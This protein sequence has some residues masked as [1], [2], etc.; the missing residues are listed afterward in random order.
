MAEDAD[1]DQKTEDPTDKKKRDAVGEG[2]VLQSRELAAALVISMGAVWLFAMGPMIMEAIGTM[3]GEGLRFDA[4]DLEHFD[5][6]ARALRLLAVV[7][8]PVAALFGLTLLAAIGAP[9]MLGSLGFRGSAL[10]FKA[11]RI[12]PMTGIK[13]IFSM[14][15]VIEL[16]KSF[17]KIALIG[18]VGWFVLKGASDRIMAI[19]GEELVPAISEL[20]S[21]FVWLVIVMA[22]ALMAIAMVDVPAQFL[23][24]LGRLRMTKQEV[25]DEGKQADGSPE[26]KQAIRRKQY[27]MARGSARKA[28]AEATV[29]LV[30]PTH[31]A[32]ALRYRPGYDAAPVLLAR[33]RGEMARAIRDAAG[34][35]G[36]PVLSYPALARAIYFTSRTGDLIREDLYIAVATILAFVFNLDRAMAEGV[37]QPEV[38]VPEGALY[39]EEGRKENI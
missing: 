9:A 11:N 16:L 32:V 39:D 30:N 35:A 14:T 3:L 28:V 31:F 33:G 25:K 38:A 21:I 20:G 37:K 29:I 15:G 27:E 19:G 5:P 18:A 4:A 2:D 10:A 36:V 7:L 23:Q 24:R 34:E 22:G 8:L 26:I 13:R 6:A 12:N 1:K 17:A